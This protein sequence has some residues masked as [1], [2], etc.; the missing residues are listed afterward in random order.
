M[1][2]MK[3]IV[4][5]AT[6]LLAGFTT[7]GFAGTAHEF[8]V[9]AYTKISKKTIGK[10]ITGNVDADKMQSDMEKLVAMGVE[11][12][13]EHMGEPETPAVEKKLMQLTIDN[14]DKMM[15]MPLADIERDFHEGGTAKA[16]GIPID[17]FSHFDEVMCH[18]DAVVHP[19]TAVICLKEYKKSQDDDLLEQIKAELE[20]VIKHLT[21]LD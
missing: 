20:E 7:N 13:K 10:I 1:R 19:A 6:L 15:N 9:K 14:A 11:G 5:M 18:Y 17:K 3:L 2:S 12:C 21:H 16:A 4:F 8:D